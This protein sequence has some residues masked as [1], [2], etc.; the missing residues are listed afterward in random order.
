LGSVERTKNLEKEG[1][2]LKI[3]FF[4]LKP[5]R[6]EKRTFLRK[7]DTIT[8]VVLVAALI[9]CILY[10]L[11]TSDWGQGFRAEYGAMNVT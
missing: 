11:I 10:M 6:A 3:G 7:M 9:V 2:S 1:G 5:T 4:K 8:K